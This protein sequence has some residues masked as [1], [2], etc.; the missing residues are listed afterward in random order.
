LDYLGELWSSW[1]QWFAALEESHTSLSMLA[2][3]RSPS[4]D[5]SWVTA[6][7]TV[8]DAAAISASALD[9]PVDPR[10]NLCIRAGYL[11]LRS[12]ADMYDI[13][14]DPDPKPGD[15]ISILREEFDAAL[16]LLDERGIPL[17]QD[18]EQA[19][20]DYAGWRVN[21]DRVLLRLAD[22]TMAPFAVWSSDRSPINLKE[23]NGKAQT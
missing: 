6:S 4:P 17:R 14:Y 9:I 16:D 5:R 22:L 1:E 18:R 23:P 3:F 12:I 13:E 10:S 21:Y 7:G 20:I 2:F 8:L 19:W 11:A 15:T